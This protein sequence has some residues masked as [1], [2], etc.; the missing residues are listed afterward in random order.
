MLYQCNFNNEPCS[1]TDFIPFTPS[2]YGACYTFNTKLKNTNAKPL[3]PANKNDGD[4]LWR[5]RFIH[6]NTELPL[7]ETSG[8]ELA[9]GRKHK[10]G[11]RKKAIH[12]LS[13]P[14]TTCTE[15]V[16]LMMQAMLDNYNGAD[17]QY[18]ETVCGQLCNQ[19][20]A[21]EQCDC[22]NAYPWSGRAIVVPGTDKMIVAPV[23]ESTDQ[24]YKKAI[25][26]LLHSSLLMNRYCSPQ[27][28]KATFITQK[29]GL[30]TLV[31]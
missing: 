1:A 3:L 15:T 18:S 12:F 7:I 5:R 14:Y 2:I 23:C 16:S 20:Y 28:S 4:G 8:I 22:V 27:C 19:V 17:Y 26:S 31:E 11:Y 10:L 6:D 9:P 24:C 29:S 30:S 25:E 13:P 21:Y